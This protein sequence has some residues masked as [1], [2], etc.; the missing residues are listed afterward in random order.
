MPP[1]RQI[2]IRAPIRSKKTTG[3]HEPAQSEKL[4]FYWFQAVS[5]LAEENQNRLHFSYFTA[6]DFLSM[7]QDSMCVELYSDLLRFHNFQV[8]RFLI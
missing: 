6:G 4:L 3:M 2:S 8:D 5:G 7:V 1:P